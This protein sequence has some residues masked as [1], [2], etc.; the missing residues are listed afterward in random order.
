MTKDRRREGDGRPEKRDP[1][2][3]L[4][5]TPASGEPFRWLPRH[6][7]PS[8]VGEWLTQHIVKWVAEPK[9]YI[10][11]TVTVTLVVQLVTLWLVWS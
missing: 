10:A 2:I 5:F 1:E 9:H 11:I 7:E 8:C 6:G 4:T 3:N